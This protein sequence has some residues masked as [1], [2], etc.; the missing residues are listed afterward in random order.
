MAPVIYLDTHVASWLYSAR[1]DLFPRSVLERIEAS[2]LL[3]SPAVHLELQYLHEIGRLRSPAETVVSALSRE[4]ELRVCELP[5]TDV[6]EE[7]LAASW[8]RD[9]FDRLIASQASLRQA[10]LLT[11]D[12]NI[13]AHCRWAA[14]GAAESGVEA[15][16]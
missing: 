9:P 4:V 10:P 8:T 2:R 11:K 15:A 5:F 7:A 6:V 1:L 14:W 3:I 12:R 16:P 13:H